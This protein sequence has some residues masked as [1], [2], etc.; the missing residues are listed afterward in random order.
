MRCPLL[1]V[2]PDVRFENVELVTV[3]GAL[4]ALY[5][6]RKTTELI[7]SLPLYRLVPVHVPTNRP[8]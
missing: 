2:L 4:D 6:V 5:V 3:L 1:A 8:N 7:N